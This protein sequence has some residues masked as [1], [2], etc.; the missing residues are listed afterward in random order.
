MRVLPNSEMVEKGRGK[1]DSRSRLKWCNVDAI[2]KE[3]VE[4]GRQPGS[5]Y[6][7]VSTFLECFKRVQVVPNDW[8]LAMF[9]ILDTRDA[10]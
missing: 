1:H 2:R 7:W 8:F 5:P 9:V 4:C 6:G 3:M 10:S